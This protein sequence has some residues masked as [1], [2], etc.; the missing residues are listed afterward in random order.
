MPVL[1]AA[2]LDKPP[3]LPLRP[4]IRGCPPG[5]GARL[6]VAHRLA[7]IIRMDEAE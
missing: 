2:R 7:Q 3:V 1:Q 4:T 6:R 5:P